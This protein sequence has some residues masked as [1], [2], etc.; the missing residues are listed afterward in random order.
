LQ[1]G[2]VPDRQHR[3]MTTC[4]SVISAATMVSTTCD[5]REREREKER[6]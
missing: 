5:E 6:E 2:K 4:L 1:S 3:H